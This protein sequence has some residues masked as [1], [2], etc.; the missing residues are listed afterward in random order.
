MGDVDV[1][2][3]SPDA[4]RDAVTATGDPELA[5]LT[6]E[7]GSYVLRPAPRQGERTRLFHVMPVA[8][9]HPMAFMIAVDGDSGR[10]TVTTGRPDAVREVVAADPALRTPDAVWELIRDEQHGGLVAA[11]LAGGAAGGEGRYEF[12]VRDRDTDGVVR[13][14]LQLSG[15]GSTWQRAG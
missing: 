11:E 15:H 5:A 7:P 14:R 12:R 4:V 1:P 9:A 13:W 6:A 10:A 3:P 2:E 8:T